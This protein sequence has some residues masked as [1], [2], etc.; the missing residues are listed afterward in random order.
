MKTKIGIECHVELNTK[1]K[2]FCSCPT[3]AELPNT[4]VCDTCVGFPGSKPRIN[5]KAIE[6]ATK[7]CLAL[8][9][10]IAKQLIFS[11]KT[12]FYPDMSK[13]FQITQFEFPIGAKGKINITNKEINI[14]RI[15]LEEDPAGLVHQGNTVLVDY[16]RSGH[17]LCEIVTE[18]EMESPEEAREFMK[19]LI[20]ILNYLKILEGCERVEIKNITGFKEIERAI[21]YEIERQKKLVSEGTPIKI[22]ETRGWNADQGITLFQRSKESEDDYGYISE[23]DLVPIDLTKEFVLNIEKSLPEL[24]QE[25]ARRYLTEYKIKKEDAEV[26]AN[27]YELAQLYENSMKKNISPIFAAEWIKRE[28]SRVLN[29]NKKELDETFIL[30]NL[31]DIL[32]LIENKKI[33]RQ[34]GQKLMEKLVKE[35][36]KIKEYVKENN[37]E[38]VSNTKELEEL[39][40][41]VINENQKVLE[42]YKQGSQK[43]FMFL[44]GQVMK[45]SKGKAD[46]KS[47]NE[48]LNK[49]IKNN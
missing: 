29:Y 48:I 15:Q 36:L 27:D 25:K 31:I 47:V 41:K 10:S 33:T 19:K 4:A 34:T 39:C 9:C 21:T 23:P 43:S 38:V 40:K 35:D 44:I 24:P 42:E 3:I 22:K 20:T 46:P 1:S 8:K 32:E 17:P 5:E 18:P 49:I 28:V 6:F 45:S 7:L 2:L 37:L 26:I 12:Y 30:K 13:N 14:T 16:N 11:R